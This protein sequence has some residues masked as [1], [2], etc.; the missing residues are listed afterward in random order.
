[1]SHPQN[2]ISITLRTPN[3]L[4]EDLR[5]EKYFVNCQRMKT[6]RDY[7]REEECRSTSPYHSMIESNPANDSP[8]VEGASF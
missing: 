5:P 1:M 2:R 7:Y 8:L 4:R 3:H 6:L